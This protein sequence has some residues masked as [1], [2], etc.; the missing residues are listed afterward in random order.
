MENF[1]TDYTLNVKSVYKDFKFGLLYQNKRAARTTN[2][3]S[4]GTDYLDKNTLWNIGFLNTYIRHY[5]DISEVL[6]AQ[7]KIVYRNS[8]VYDNTIA[9]VTDTSQ[10]G[11]YRPSYSLRGES[12]LYYIPTEYLKITGGAVFEA[13]WLSENFSVK[14]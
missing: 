9:Y 6:N 12:I 2:Y 3:K 11:Y 1:E 10:V 14:Y 4:V 5:I 7:S 8:T 13:E